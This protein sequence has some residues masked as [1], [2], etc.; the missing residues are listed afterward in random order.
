MARRRPP[1]TSHLDKLTSRKVPDR[2]STWAGR[3]LEFAVRGIRSDEVAT[4]IARHLER[5]RHFFHENYG[6]DRVSACLRRDVTAWRDAL[7]KDGLAASTIN[8]HLSSLSGFASW[9][10]A[11][12]PGLFPAGNPARGIGELGLPPLEPKALTIEQVRSLKNLCDRL[13]RCY[14]L[15]GRRWRQ[16]LTREAPLGARSRPLR[17]RAIIFFLL[18]TGLRRSEL[19]GLDRKQLEPSDPEGLRH[20]RVAR[21]RGVQGKRRSQR[22]VFLS[23]DARHALAD[24]LEEEW[25]R[26]AGPGSN[27][28]FLSANGL[29]ARKG[30]G[31]LTGRAVNVLVE[32]IGRWHDAETVD[33]D[34]RIGVLS[35]HVL[36]HTFGFL[37]ARMT[38][39][40][41]Y[42]L[43]RR[44]G[45]RSQRYIQRYTNP[46][47]TVAAG[48]VE[49][50]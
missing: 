13:Q 8:G 42:E 4:K 24:Y 31:R 47:E 36:R 25:P 3:Y 44:L 27:A 15:K 39:A 32:K 2:L 37:L 38:G 7:V 49:A 26:D 1:K 21:V 33:S 9:L 5:F 16:T 50:F 19:V 29:P 17:D 18:S 10:D 35:P 22:T 28:L 45:H 23:R 41:T 48:Y 6:H 40:D 20:A 11:Q 14:Q 30:D 12:A 34:R 43:E 46:P